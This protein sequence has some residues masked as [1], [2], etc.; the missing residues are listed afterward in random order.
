MNENQDMLK[1][2]RTEINEKGMTV[3]FVLLAFILL[4]AWAMTQPF[5]AGPDE[6]MRYLVAN[7]IYTHHGALP[8]GD[9]EAVRNAT[10]GISYAYYPVV[11]YMVSAVFMGI[12]RLFGNPGNYMFRAARMADV[13]FVTG[14]VYFLVKAS[15]KLFPKEKYSGEA[16]WLFTALAGF[17]PQAIF[18]G[19]YV[20]TDSLALL[21]AALLLY[22]WASFLREDWT[23]KNCILL[24]VGMALCALSYYNAYGWILCSF[25][26]F[27]LTVLLCRDEAPAQRLRFLFSR[28][29]AIAGVTL[30][31][32]GWWFVRNGILYNGDILGR[33]ACAACAEKYALKDYRPSNY[34]TPQKLGWT[35]KDILLY[36]DPGWYHN[37]VVTVCVSFIG[38]FGLMEIYMPYTVSRIYIIF[39]AAGIFGTFSIPGMFRL[40]KRMYLT[41]KKKVDTDKWKIKIK[42]ISKKWNKQG[43]FHLVMLLAIVIPTVLFMIYVYYNDNQAQGRYLI[44]ALY[45]LMYFVTVGWNRIL[46]VTVRNRKVRGWIY[47]IFTALFVISPF[48]CWAF[49]V[50]PFYAGQR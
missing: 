50:M 26:L 49:L 8:R 40:R 4:T 27:C 32:C 17:M 2:K 3:V 38:T 1:K 10:W 34:P 36:Q 39:F 29:F 25:L 18:L 20:N 24:G 35:W 37:W 6:H 7:Y 30:G 16:R 9:D 11:S 15:G 41:K 23:W 14:A 48:I 45:P 42:V 22:V 12:V 31:L 13:L 44:S 28:G 47:R 46:T 43:M 33:K 21:A 19:T 5:N